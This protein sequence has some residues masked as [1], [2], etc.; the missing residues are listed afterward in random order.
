MRANSSADDPRQGERPRICCHQRRDITARL[1]GQTLA[2]SQ[3][4][5]KKS[6]FRKDISMRKIKFIS[7]LLVLSMLL[8]VPAFAFSL[9]FTDV[10]ENAVYAESVSYLADAGILRGTASGRFSPNEKITRSVGG[11]AL[12]CA[13]RKTGGRVLAGSKH[14]RCP[15]CRPKSVV[16]ADR[17]W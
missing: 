15:D 13:G 12:P 9:D 6:D 8:T 14:K 4:R 16:A 2:E 17:D 1:E 3:Y 5:K 7:I 11:D 10:P